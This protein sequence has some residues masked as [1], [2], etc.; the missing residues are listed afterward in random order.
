[1]GYEIPIERKKKWGKNRNR[2]WKE[3]AER[4]AN[5]RKPWRRRFWF[6]GRVQRK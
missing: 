5:L 4:E 2:A 3:V 1:M 6:R